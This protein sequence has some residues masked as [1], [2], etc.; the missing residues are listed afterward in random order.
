[1]H[2]RLVLK[3]TSRVAF[4]EGILLEVTTCL[5][6]TG[7]EVVEAPLAAVTLW[8]IGMRVGSPSV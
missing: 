8:V 2:I 4:F 1:M 7:T 5:T 6:V 3:L